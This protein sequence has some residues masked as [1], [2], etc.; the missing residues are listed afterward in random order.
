MKR[1]NLLCKFNVS[2]VLKFVLKFLTGGLF[3]KKPVLN[4]SMPL[5]INSAEGL[6]FARISFPQ[7]RKGSEKLLR[8]PTATFFEFKTFYYLIKYF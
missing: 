6:F 1:K 8:T 4:P 2:T 5:G 3:T 7:V